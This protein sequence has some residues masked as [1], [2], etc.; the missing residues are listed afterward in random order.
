MPSAHSH[1]QLSMV[2]SG[3]SYTH[4]YVHDCT[5][6]HTQCC[7]CCVMGWSDI[8]NL[9]SS[10]S[11]WLRSGEHMEAMELAHLN[12]ST[13]TKIWFRCC[14]TQMRKWA[15]SPLC[16]N[17]MWFHI[18]WGIFFMS[19]GEKFTK[20]LWY[21]TSVSLC[22]KTY[23]SVNQHD[24]CPH[25]KQKSLLII[26]LQNHMGIFNCLCKCCGSW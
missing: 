20:K 16:M 26:W 2:C 9:H 21:S 17:H 12:V 4:T 15:G 6:M 3:L 7:N 18:Y 13:F 23:Y 8:N 14:L 25:I 5:H 24:T 10:G 11:I 19:L 22:G 1:T